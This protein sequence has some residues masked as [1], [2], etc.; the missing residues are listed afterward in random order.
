MGRP[1]NYDDECNCHCVETSPSPSIATTC[2]NNSKLS[3]TLT[4]TVE[5]VDG[6]C[7]CLDG[8]SLVIEYDPSQGAWHG[9]K[10]PS[11][12]TSGVGLGVSFRCLS[13]NFLLRTGLCCGDCTSFVEFDATYDCGGDTCADFGGGPSS[14]ESSP[15][16]SCSPYMAVFERN[17]QGSCP[18]CQPPGLGADNRLRF[19]VTE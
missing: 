17:H 4:V 14:P 13:G 11:G 3:P 5:D 7:P 18:D 1:P 6:N 19:T 8:E 10:Q 16:E 15:A 2:C 12:C 9:E